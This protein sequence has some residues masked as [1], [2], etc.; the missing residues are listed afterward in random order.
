LLSQEIEKEAMDVVVWGSGEDLGGQAG[1]RDI[2]HNI[3]YEK[4]QCST[5]MYLHMIF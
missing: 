1:S 4:Y 2:D 3:M 5:E